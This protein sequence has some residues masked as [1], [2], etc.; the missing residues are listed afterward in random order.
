MES[1]EPVCLVPE[2]V[3]SV[4][5][6]DERELQPSSWL[7]IEGEG[8]EVVYEVVRPGTREDS[9]RSEVSLMPHPRRLAYVCENIN[10]GKHLPQFPVL[11]T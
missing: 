11:G 1:P 3:T 9:D 6:S 10:G 7:G 8:D 2:L 4:V 5:P